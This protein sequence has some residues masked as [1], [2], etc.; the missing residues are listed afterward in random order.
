[1]WNFII[2]N[3]ILKVLPLKFKILDNFGIFVHFF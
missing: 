2:K 1:M 3:I